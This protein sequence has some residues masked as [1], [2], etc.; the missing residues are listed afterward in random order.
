MNARKSSVGTEFA[1]NTG[2]LKKKVTWAATFYVGLK[3]F[4]M[5]PE[6]PLTVPIILR[7]IIEESYSEAI[8]NE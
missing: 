8:L 6:Y 2:T 4:T 1:E 3:Q 7:S 5:K